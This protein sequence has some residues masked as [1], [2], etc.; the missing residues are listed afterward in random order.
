MTDKNIGNSRKVGG[1]FFKLVLKRDSNHKLDYY[2][3]QFNLDDYYIYKCG[4]PFREVSIEDLYDFRY[5][6]YILFRR[7]SY[8]NQEINEWIDF[9][10]DIQRN[11]I[12]YL[13]KPFPPKEIKEKIKIIQ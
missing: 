5:T 2:T 11:Y 12:Q 4:K 13:H 1:D 3:N 7:D 10:S 8:C 6:G 9:V